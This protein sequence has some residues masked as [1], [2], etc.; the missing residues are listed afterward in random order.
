MEKKEQKMT[1]QQFLRILTSSVCGIILCLV[2]LVSTTWAWYTMDITCTNNVIRVGN[3]DPV[4]TVAQGELTLAA[5]GEN[6]YALAAGTYQIQIESGSG[7]TSPGCC[8]LRLWGEQLYQT[9]AVYPGHDGA[10]EP[11]CVTFTLILEEDA[12][13]ELIPVLGMPTAALPV[14]DGEEI[15]PEKP[16]V[17]EESTDLQLPSDPPAEPEIP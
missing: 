2:G 14:V 6:T 4:V 17:P 13:L 11:S 7:S 10:E 8:I 15:A 9:S 1:E 5:D 3:F 12:E 16:T